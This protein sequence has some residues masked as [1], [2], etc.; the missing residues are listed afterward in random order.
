[1]NMI[2]SMK[3]VVLELG[4]RGDSYKRTIKKP[5]SSFHTFGSENVP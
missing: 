1:M 2:M 5:I 4:T 3:L